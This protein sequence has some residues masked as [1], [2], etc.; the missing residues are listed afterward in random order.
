MALPAIQ[1]ATSEITW[2]FVQGFGRHLPVALLFLSAREIAGGSSEELRAREENSVRFSFR[3]FRWFLAFLFAIQEVNRTFGAVTNL[4]MGA[5]VMDSC[6]DAKEALGGVSRLLSGEPG[7]FMSYR[8]WGSPPRLSAVLGDAGEDSAISLAG[9]LGLYSYPQIS[10]FTPPAK[11]SNHFLFPSTLSVAPTLSSHAKGLVRLLQAFGWS[12]VGVL[13]QETGSSALAQTFMEEFMS[14]G[15]CLAFWEAVPTSTQDVT[16]VA[17]IVRQST[18]TVVVVFSLEAYLNP[19]LVE[20][21]HS[22]DSGNRIWI[23]TGAWTA[24][25]RLV[26]PW[27]SRFLRGTLGLVLRNG[28]ALGFK[29]FVFDLNPSKHNNHPLFVEFW[30]EAFSCQWL[31]RD[32]YVSSF[33][34]KNATYESSTTPATVR[35]PAA[36]S[37][38]KPLCTGTEDPASLQIFSDINDMRVT[39]NSYKAVKMVAKALQDM[40]T[41]LYPMKNSSDKSSCVDIQQFQPW[42]LLRYLRRVRLKGNIGDDLY[43][44]SLGNA[45]AIYDIINWQEGLAEGTSWVQVGSYES[46]ALLGQDLLINQS[47]IQWKEGFSQPPASVCSENCHPGFRKALRRDKPN[48][49]FDCIPCATGEISNNTNAI[50]CVQCPEDQWPNEGRN[51]CTPRK[52]DLLT[53]S[54]PLGTSLGTVSILSSI[55]PTFV[56]LLLIKNRETPLVRANNCTLSFILLVALLV[57]FLCP[58]LLLVPPGSQTCFIR[59]AAFG[60]TFALCISCLLA[61]TVIVVLAFRANHPGGCLRVPRGPR[62]PVLFAIQCTAVQ[63]ALCISWILVDPPNPEND[64]RSLLGKIIVQC[65]DGLGF[66]FMLGYLG[67]LSTVCFVVAFLARKLPGAFNEATHITFSMLVFLSVWISFV[68]AYLSTHGKLAVATEIFAIL[69]SSAGLLFCI[70][71]PK[72]YIIL[73]KP[74]LNTRAVISGHQKRENTNTLP[75]SQPHGRRRHK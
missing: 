71:S 64:T 14:S 17:D 27:L 53:L 66:W 52:M 35:I 62:W 69:S 72:V 47:A 67:L 55:L 41:C 8:C 44:D 40:A 1:C 45:P 24:T 12:W 63:L 54:E 6:S 10:Y 60:V 59:Q 38:T 43:F 39:Y 28:A 65:N 46:G 21:A 56:L 7:G 25:P 11:L 4:T 37:S 20:L 29:E 57:S 73:L 15:A 58:I 34:P 68:P 50:D 16:R 49:C 22:G 2:L 18:A 3:C 33:P 70:F 19:V 23:A 13:S 9:I 31:T 32:N 5:A 26:A 74:Q 36:P 30:E 51:K 48:C 75:G 61:K 42:Q